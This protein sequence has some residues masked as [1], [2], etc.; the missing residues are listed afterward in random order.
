MQSSRAYQGKYRRILQGC[1]IGKEHL[2]R[3][4]VFVEEASGEIL[5]FY[6]LIVGDEPE[7]DLMFVSDVAQGT[8][9]GRARFKH[10]LDVA[11]ATASALC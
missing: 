11:K 8:G 7:L 1:A 3:D 5:G 10:M 2:E 9:A 6:S 4:M